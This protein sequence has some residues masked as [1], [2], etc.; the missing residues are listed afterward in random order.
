M[1]WNGCLVVYVERGRDWSCCFYLL[2]CMLNI[3]VIQGPPGTGKSYIGMQL[4][5]L[6]LS[7]KNSSGKLI[8][9]NKPALIIA[10]KN[11]ALDLFIKMCTSFCSL[12]RIVR[13]GHL[14][15]DNEEEL[16]CTLLNE[17]VEKVMSGL[18]RNR[19]VELKAAMERQYER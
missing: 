2:V 6:F 9:E 15:K 8:L 16:R 10:Y 18:D 13:I 11:R 19:T 1:G 4:L 7:M 17:K 12:D 3:H 5:R 14:S